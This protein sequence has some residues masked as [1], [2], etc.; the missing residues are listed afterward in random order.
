MK[1]KTQAIIDAMVKRGYTEVS[2]IKSRKYRIFQAGAGKF[3][4]VG[5]AAAVRFNTTPKVAGAV[6]IADSAKDKL[7]KEGLE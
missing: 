6:P 3:Y 4:L 1:T 7:V 5:Q 2:N